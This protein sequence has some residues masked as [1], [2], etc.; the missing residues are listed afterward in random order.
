M[1]SKDKL[2]IYFLPLLLLILF[3]SY[4]YYRF[5]E[6]NI[7]QMSAIVKTPFFK[8]HYFEVQKQHPYFE[9]YQLAE[10]YRNTNT[11][12]VYIFEKQD[13]SKL[14]YSGTYYFN[15]YFNK[16]K[17]PQKYF[18]SELGIMINYFFYPRIIKPISVLQYSQTKFN[19]GT[20]IISDYPLHDFPKMFPGVKLNE[21]SYKDF[22]KANKR[23]EESYYIYEVN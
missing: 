16:G 7:R 23:P 21:L 2:Y 17:P 22:H 8:D 19:K 4:H 20:A 13:D 1:K 5:Y 10:K 6:D 9:I 14:D 3:W 15:K 12:I 11:K 18:L